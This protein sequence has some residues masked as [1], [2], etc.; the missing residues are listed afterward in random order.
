MIMPL[1]ENR[2]PFALLQSTGRHHAD[3]PFEWRHVETV[4]FVLIL[5]NTR[6]GDFMT[7]AAPGRTFDSLEA[8]RAAARSGCHPGLRPPAARRLA[9]RSGGRPVPRRGQLR[10]PRLLEDWRNPR[11]LRYADPRGAGGW[12]GWGGVVN[13]VDKSELVKTAALRPIVNRGMDVWD[14]APWAAQAKTAEAMQVVC[15]RSYSGLTVNAP[16]IRSVADLI[17]L[18]IQAWQTI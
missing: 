1:R 3:D 13:H 12:G 9:N 15:R 18:G 6:T 8:S 5:Q 2:F 14:H 10:H 4:E 16:A 7:S 11:A 17:S